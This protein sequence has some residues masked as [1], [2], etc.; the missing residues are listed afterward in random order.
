MGS[1][2]R[3]A[4]D[5]LVAVLL[6]E[7]QVLVQA[8]ADVVAV[9]AVGGQAEVEEV[10]LER[11]GDGGLARGGQAGQPDGEAALLA[12]LIALAAGERRVPGDVAVQPSVVLASLQRL[13]MGGTAMAGQLALGESGWRGRGADLRSHGYVCRRVGMRGRKRERE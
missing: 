2:L 7:T 5:V 13:V 11:G 4:A 12:E 1:Y 10:L 6:G 8:E 9:E 3:D